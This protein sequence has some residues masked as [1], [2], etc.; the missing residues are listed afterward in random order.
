MPSQTFV[1][2]HVCEENKIPGIRAGFLTVS[3]EVNLHQNYLS[4]YERSS[5]AKLCLTPVET[6]SLAM[7]SVAV[8][9]IQNEV[10]GPAAGGDLLE[11]QTLGPH[12]RQ[13]ESAIAF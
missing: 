2:H 9:R 8:L 11:F 4:R 7:G 5:K 13:T 6:E 3:S 10:S 1:L 12:P